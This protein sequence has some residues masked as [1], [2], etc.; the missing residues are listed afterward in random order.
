MP[1]YST[2]P[3]VSSP[4]DFSLAKLW[5]M[6]STRILSSIA[7]R[8]YGSAT[9]GPA[10]GFGALGRAAGTLGQKFRQS[11]IWPSPRRLAVP[12]RGQVPA[13]T[14]RAMRRGRG[15]L[16]T[17]L[18]RGAC[19]NIH[20]AL[21]IYFP[22]FSGLAALVASPALIPD[23]R[24]LF[25]L[26]LPIFPHALLAGHQPSLLKPT[27]WKRLICANVRYGKHSI[28][29]DFSCKALC[30]AAGGKIKNMF[31]VENCK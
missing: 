2:G 30:F 28:L 15:C 22:G 20:A 27:P 21:K 1:S 13:W 10:G 5:L 23:L 12:C 3:A 14:S 26:Q 25:S 19:V 16:G 31:F 24:W 18:Q 7:C 8:P 9:T 11:E 6:S 17:S 29:D 4:F